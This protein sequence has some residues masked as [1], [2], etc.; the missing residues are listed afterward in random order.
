M[1]FKYICLFVFLSFHASVLHAGYNIKQ[2]FQDEINNKGGGEEAE[3]EEVEGEEGNL[4][5]TTN[6]SSL[7]DIFTKTQGLK[8][9]ISD[10]RCQSHDE[11]DEN[12]I[13][14]YYQD[15]NLVR[16][17]LENYETPSKLFKK[18]RHIF[19]KRPYYISVNETDKFKMTK[20]LE[21]IYS[22]NSHNMDSIFFAMDYDMV[23]N[24]IRKKFKIGYDTYYLS[25]AIV[26]GSNNEYHAVIFN[27]N[28]IGKFKIDEIYY[29]DK[30]ETLDEDGDRKNDYISERT[31]E[32]KTHA[33]IYV[34]KYQSRKSH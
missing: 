16:S 4:F 30:N 32:G 26:L 11:E 5:Q 8:G 2:Y 34:R 19:Y 24:S 25:S 9:T 1:I 13:G 7:L 3:A 14:L 10:E 20:N 22:K 18:I 23:L 27:K 6:F 12:H 31:D 28:G 29:E 33:L 21:E 15:V 17:L